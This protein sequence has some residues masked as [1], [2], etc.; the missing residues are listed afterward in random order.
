M[1][2][3]GGAGAKIFEARIMDFSPDARMARIS[4]V[5]A[6]AS[7]GGSLWNTGTTYLRFDVAGPSRGTDAITTTRAGRVYLG[8]YMYIRWVH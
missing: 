3:G 7:R 2:P 8:A 6:R 1:F 4:R 5:F